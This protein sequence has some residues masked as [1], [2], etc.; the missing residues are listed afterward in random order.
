[1]VGNVFCS[2]CLPSGDDIV[3]EL[4]IA[5]KTLELDCT[6]LY[7]VSCGLVFDAEGKTCC[8][9]F[10]PSY[11]V[12]PF[13]SLPTAQYKEPPHAALVKFGIIEFCFQSCPSG[14]VY[15]EPTEDNKS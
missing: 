6:E 14:E 8:V 1:M 7:A 12:A 15:A 3:F 5:Q 9:Q 13:P 10:I 4:D 11:D 2:Q